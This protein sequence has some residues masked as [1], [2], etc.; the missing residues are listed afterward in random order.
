MK[1]LVVL[2]LLSLLSNICLGQD[3]IYQKD[4]TIIKAKILEIDLESIKYKRI[5]LPEGPIYT[6]S[7]DKLFKV[8]FSNGIE[9]IIDTT[10][11]NEEMFYKKNVKASDSVNYSLIYVVYNYH[12]YNDKVPMYFNDRFILKLKNQNRFRYK[13]YSEGPLKIERFDGKKTGPSLNLLI[14]HGK[15]YGIKID[16]PYP[17][18]LHPKKRFRMQVFSDSTEFHEFLQND[19]YSFKPFPKEDFY[20]EEDPDNP[21]IK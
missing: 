20:F 17:Y 13:L 1:S 18:G 19:F 11:Y 15:F 7:K 21:L 8:R 4:Y 10:G 2:I 9:D 14:I 3:Y 6:I 16:I 12:G 5:E